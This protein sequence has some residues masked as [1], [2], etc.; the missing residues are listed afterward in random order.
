MN[1]FS[2]LFVARLAG[3]LTAPEALGTVLPDLLP[4][5]GSRPDAALLP[6]EV[7]VGRA[8]HHRTDHLFHRHGAFTSLVRGLRGTLLAAGLGPGTCHAGA[9]VG[10]ELLLDGTLS[11]PALV[12]AFREAVALGQLVHPAL[13]P[14]GRS[15]WDEVTV[16]VATDDPSSLADPG[17]VGR[18]LFRVLGRRS[19]LT[20]ALHDVPVVVEALRLHRPGV[21]DAAAGLLSDVV[22]DLAHATVPGA[23][24]LSPVTA[25]QGHRDA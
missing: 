15:R 6:P 8:L 16:R 12:V 23:G 11:D 20:L 4:I 14:E 7:L 25:D 19:R 17:E 22:G 13:P 21:V 18:R 9:H 2:H 3:P 10:V 24:T 1:Y 5:A